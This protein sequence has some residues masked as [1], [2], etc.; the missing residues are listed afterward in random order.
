MTAIE[1]IRDRLNQPVS[2]FPLITFRIFFGLLMAIAT[3]RFLANGWVSELY[4]R[5]RYHFP[6]FGWQWIK[7]YGEFFIYLLFALLLIFS[8]F[9]LAGFLYRFAAAGFFLV[10]SYIELIDKTY[11]LNHYYFII[12]VS[13]LMI[14]LP[15]NRYCALDLFVFRRRQPVKKVPAWAVLAPRLQIFILYFFAGLAKI[16]SDWL[17]HALPLKLWLPPLSHVPVLGYWFGQAWVAYLLSWGGCIFD[18]SVGFL[19]FS[20]SFRLPAYIALTAFHLVTGFLFPIGMFPYVMIVLAAVFFSDEWHK[21]VL[22]RFQSL[23]FYKMINW[24]KEF[25]RELPQLRSPVRYLF[26]LFFFLQVIIPLRY[27]LYPGKLFWTEEGFR[28]SWRVMLIEKAGTI[29]FTVKDPSTQRTYSIVNRDYL[30]PLQEKMVATQP[31]MIVDMA[32]LLESDFRRRGI[33]APTVYAESYV[34]LNGRPSRLLT[35]PAYDLVQARNNFRH[36]KFITLG[37]AD[38]W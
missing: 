20:K 14:F 13:F 9:I 2:I 21:K 23:P 4:V 25:A 7:V 29:F 16:N 17:L 10:F 26:L 3:V 27:L 6:F 19:L 34:T 5:P 36:K 18:L 24:P 12:L 11:Y 38:L 22:L 33:S 37:P 8:L 28:F 31:D 30:T 1:K 35:D 32:H 15:A